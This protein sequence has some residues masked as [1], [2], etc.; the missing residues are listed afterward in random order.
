MKTLRQIKKT[1]LYIVR[2]LDHSYTIEYKQN[3]CLSFSIENSLKFTVYQDTSVTA[4]VYLQNSMFLLMP[5]YSIYLLK[6]TLV[7][8][9]NRIWNN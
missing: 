6:K 7:Q 8:N 9:S 3:R 2:I 5:S 1:V 4:K